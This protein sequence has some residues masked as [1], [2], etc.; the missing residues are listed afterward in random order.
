MQKLH[1]NNVNIFFCAR[2]N[3]K[4]KV[5]LPL[6]TILLSK[7]IKYFENGTRTITESGERI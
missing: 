4:G 5:K 2:N 1:L 6:N 7:V 3:K